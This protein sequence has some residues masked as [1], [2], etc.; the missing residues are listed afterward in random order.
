MF[1]KIPLFFSLMIAAIVA[2]LTSGI[3]ITTTMNLLIGGMGT[4]SNTALSYI[5]LGS[6]AYIM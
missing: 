3:D 6:L 4:N 5:L 2:G 1:I